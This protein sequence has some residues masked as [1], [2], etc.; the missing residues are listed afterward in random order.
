MPIS[1]Q[2]LLS[3]VKPTI[4]RWIEDK[5]GAGGG[6][7][8]TAV[9]AGT[10][11]T[12]G[13]VSGAVTLSLA[14][15]GVV[16][17]KLGD[18]QVTGAKL[19]TGA[20]VAHLGYTPFNRAGDTL[21][22]DM[23]VNGA[24]RR[25]DTGGAILIYASTTLANSPG[26][27]QVQLYANGSILPGQLY[28]DSGAHGSAA[29]VLRTAGA[30]GNLADRLRLDALGN[31]VL[32]SAA[33]TT[34]ATDG[35]LY[36]PSMPGVPTGTPAAFTGRVPVVIDATND[37]LYFYTAGSWKTGGGGAGTVTNV[38]TGAGLTG[39]PITTTG[40]LA[41]ATGGVA[42]AMLADGAVLT[43]KIGDAQV[44]V[45]KLASGAAAGNLAAG[46]ITDTML[47]TAKV[48]RAG[49]TM[50][51]TLTL[52][53]GDVNSG[54]NGWAGLVFEYNGGGYKHWVRSRHDATVGSA[55]NA[56]DFFVN[57][58]AT[59]GGS[60]APGTGNTLKL[61]VTAKGVGVNLSTPNEM[62]ELGS[63]N[64]AIGQT[65]YYMTRDSASARV[66]IARMSGQEELYL[67]TLHTPSG[68]GAN[69][70]SLRVNNAE[71]AHLHA[72]LD[73]TVGGGVSGTGAT[74]GFAYLP[75]V[76]GY[77]TGTPTDRVAWSPF[78]LDVTNRRLNY[79]DGTAWRAI[80]SG[81]IS[82]GTVPRATLAGYL[83]DSQIWDTGTQV[84][85]GTISPQPG[86]KLHVEGG[87]YSGGNLQTAG[88]V[89]AGGTVR[90]D[91][92]EL[93]AGTAALGLFFGTTNT[94]GV[95]SKKSAGGNQYGLDF[96]TGG[97]SRLSI[98][99]AGAVSVNGSF[100]TFSSTLLGSITLATTSTDGY[101]YLGNM[102][103]RPTGTPTSQT[104]RTALS[105]DRTNHLLD[106]YSGG[107]WRTL[108]LV[109]ARVYHNAGQSIGNA[110][111]TVVAF[112]SERWD[113]HAS[114]DNATNNSRLTA[115]VAGKYLILAHIEWQSNATGDRLLILRHNGTTF[116]SSQFIRATG[117][118]E[119]RHD[120]ITEWPLAAGDYV[121]LLAYQN[122]GGS[123]NVNSGAS[124]SPEFM[125]RRVGD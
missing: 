97:T 109:G 3:V 123:L 78:V 89:Y 72:N 9:N 62:L 36:L 58:S 124:Y 52:K 26:G 11:L 41:I 59:S 2:E 85:I 5:A 57:D 18:A 37:R 35:F 50:T 65:A 21:S 45:A 117:G 24:L 53:R 12:G 30:G 20:V 69:G 22:G 115:T 77:P 43:A 119:T 46:S 51:D 92:S 104:N 6:G 101:V 121:E 106:Y 31:V 94:E 108:G 118:F 42:A 111:L 27:P 44:T 8:I 47:Q 28:L 84:A 79:H 75:N 103:G 102:A 10:G 93:N 63:G 100:Q 116:I 74:G 33:L 83:E 113:T 38:A 66:G 23:I 99:N 120:I 90:P 95:T 81:E 122:S 64:V 71:A 29:I 4:L 112:N 56:V 55:G 17:A 14:D 40:T 54:A 105:L 34:T 70:V 15:G 25:A 39:G 87:V 86:F 49:D 114:H 125:F 60:T 88:G 110:A 91:Y 7:T 68:G 80:P 48:N 98:T 61:S 73:V 32:G 1:T 107:A 16:T 96:W 76:E 82:E 67:G 19:A 13:G